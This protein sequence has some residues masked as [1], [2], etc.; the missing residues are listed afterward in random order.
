MVLG[1]VAGRRIPI[2]N[3]MVLIKWDDGL[4]TVMIKESYVKNQVIPRTEL[5]VVV[6]RGQSVLWSLSSTWPSA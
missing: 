4:E 1:Y 3:N 5:S 6:I 2:R